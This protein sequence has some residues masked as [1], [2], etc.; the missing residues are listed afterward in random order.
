MTTSE[1]NIY[2]IGINEEVYHELT[3]DELKD[4]LKNNINEI[5]FV[6]KKVKNNTSMVLFTSDV[7]TKAD[8]YIKN[9]RSLP[10]MYG[11]D[12]LTEEDVEIIKLLNK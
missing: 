9:Y 6:S 12:P 2:S 5:Y 11:K 4:K 3:I 8:V 7:P 10:N 1:E